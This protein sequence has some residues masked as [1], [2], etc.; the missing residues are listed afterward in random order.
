MDGACTYGSER[1]LPIGLELG[2][3]LAPR[4]V[5]H[6][7]IRV[8]FGELSEIKV[9]L[10]KEQRGHNLEKERMLRSVQFDRAL[11]A[12]ETGARFSVVVDESLEDYGARQLLRTDIFA[13]SRTQKIHI[14]S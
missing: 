6:G 4:E 2:N 1:V 5:V 8:D 9:W 7:L 11:V 13:Q 14:T 10:L 12:T 3:E